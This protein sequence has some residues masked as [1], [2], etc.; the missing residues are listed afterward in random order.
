MWKQ[1]AKNYNIPFGLTE[2]LGASFSWWHV[3]KLCDKYGAYAGVPYDGANKDYFDFYH[4]NYEH[5]DGST[6][7]KA[8][9]TD[10]KTFRQYWKNVMKEIIDLFE[11]DLLFTDGPLPFGKGGQLWNESVTEQNDE[12]YKLGLEA[13]A[14]LYNTSIRKYG[15]N[16]AVYTQKDRRP[17]IYRVG[18]LDIEKS[19]LTE[20]NPDPWQTDSCIGNW[21]YDVKQTFK[22]PNHIIEML[23]DI[24]SKNGHMILNV[25]QLPDGSIDEEQRYI[26]FEIAKWFSICAEG[27]YSTRPWRV[28]GEGDSRV[29][30]DGFNE[31]AVPWNSSDYRFTCKGKTIYAYMMRVP[32]SRIAIIKSFEENEIIESVRLLGGEML[33]FSQSF[34]ILTIKLP[35]I[36]PTE[37]TNCLA[38][39]LK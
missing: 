14:Y 30:L 12:I 16:R 9:Y 35:K 33:P 7:F 6:D 24:I 21:Y 36:M 15:E 27:V 13:V 37:Y 3:N 25:L 31:N 28:Y 38:I 8:W 17:E 10:N 11:P 34:G 18:I 2:H 29:V 23:V 22:R 20:I 1:A 32:E 5:V 4:D 26:L 19:Q 39:E